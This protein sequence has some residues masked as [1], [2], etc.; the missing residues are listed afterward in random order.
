M[1]SH[2]DFNEKTTATVVAS[3][4]AEQIRNKNVVITGV[5][6]KSLGE[7]MAVAIAAQ[8]PAK[9]FLASRTKEKLEKVTKKI[10]TES[11]QATSAVE[12]VYLD[13]ASQQSIEQAASQISSSVD[14]V[15][16]LINNAGVMILTRDNT[17]DGLE[18]QFGTNHIGHFL[19]TQLLMK[20]L[21]YAGSKSGDSAR[22]INVTSEGHRLSP[23]RFN[24]YFIEGKDVPDEE[25]P[26]PQ[27]TAIYGKIKEYNGWLAYGQSKT[28]NSL[29]SL[30]LNQRLTS[31]GVIS[32]A[33]H[34]AIWTNLN[35]NLDEEGN[36]ILAKTGTYWKSE[37]E[38]AATMLVAAFDPLLNDLPG[39]GEFYLSDCQ[40]K[41]PAPWAKDT[42]A[43]DRLYQLSEKLLGRKFDT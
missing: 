27:I 37:D 6:P 23:I 33:V 31:K 1:T 41:E 13:L 42:D 32:Y 25:Q 19:F 3:A 22:V 39:P 28:A 2:P 38:G 4:F 8:S 16:V 30:A 5:A 7:A 29:F 11:P 36:S 9:L 34:P 24:D 18:L 43:A 10:S 35:R 26:P 17:A 15:D 40:F 14:A 12:L 20:Q 21:L